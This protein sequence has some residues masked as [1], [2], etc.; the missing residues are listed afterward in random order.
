MYQVFPIGTPELTIMMVGGKPSLVNIDHK[1]LV[2]LAA[3]I[4]VRSSA[5]VELKAIAVCVLERYT[6][7]PP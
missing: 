3:T 2:I 7:V 4:A 1:Y 5:S 6:I